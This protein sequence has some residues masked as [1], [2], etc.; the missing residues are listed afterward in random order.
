MTVGKRRNETLKVK[1][2]MAGI[3]IAAPV[4]FLVILDVKYF[5]AFHAERLAARIYDGTVK[6]SPASR[7]SFLLFHC[8]RRW[9]RTTALT[10]SDCYKPFGRV[11]SVQLSYTTI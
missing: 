4:L 5:P 9:H 8:C 7:A 6:C 1:N 2:V 11:R 3:V 10:P